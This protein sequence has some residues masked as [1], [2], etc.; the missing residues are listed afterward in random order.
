M[1]GLGENQVQKKRSTLPAKVKQT[2]P[3]EQA[4]KAFGTQVP[5][6]KLNATLKEAGAKAK[7]GDWKKLEAIARID[8]GLSSEE[9][10]T[11]T[12]G[13]FNEMLERRNELRNLPQPLPTIPILT[14]AEGDAS[15]RSI[16][17]Y[18]SP[19]KQAIG[20]G[21]LAIPNKGDN[22]ELRRWL[23]N[24]TSEDVKAKVSSKI[25]GEKRVVDVAISEVRRDMQ[26]PA[27]T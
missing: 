22:K 9:F 16:P 6:T 19:L 17:A 15:S 25:K 24:N 10:W 14:N 18:T 21:L 7:Y 23:I 26:F 4:L 1:S 13:E 12:P 3:L 20:R 27:W 2:N 5:I 11:L 8:L